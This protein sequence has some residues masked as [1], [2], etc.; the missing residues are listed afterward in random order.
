MVSN[1]DFKHTLKRILLSSL[2]ESVTNI[3]SESHASSLLSKLNSLKS[4]IAKVAQVDYD[5]W[6]E[7]DRDTYGGGGICHIIADS[8]AGVL[9]KHGISAHSHSLD[10]KQHVVTI[11][12]DEGEKTAYMVDIPEGIYENG[13]GFSWTKIPGVEFDEHSVYIDRIDYDDWIANDPDLYL[14]NESCAKMSLRET[15]VRMFCEDITPT[16]PSGKVSMKRITKNKGT[17]KAHEIIQYEFNTKSGNNVKVQLSPK[18]DNSYD[19][20]FYVNDTLDDASSTKGGNQRDIEILNGVLYVVKE[21]SKRLKAKEL[22][23]SAYSGKGDVKNYKNL[24]VSKPKQKLIQSF[25][26]VKSKLEQYEPVEIP[27]SELRLKL[28]KDTGKPLNTLYDLDKEKYLNVI[29][30]LEN[31]IDDKDYFIEMSHKLTDMISFDRSSRKVFTTKIDP[32]DE[33]SSN[34]TK[35]SRSLISNSEGGININKNR[36]SSL[37]DRLMNKYFS[38]EWDVSKIRDDF[39]LKKK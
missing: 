1:D 21:V 32:N 6:D 25:Q 30:D 12:Y 16:K 5:N 3:F 34:I 9:S 18:Y 37:Y 27:P 15:I 38:D 17:M 39:V 22:T 8:V 28:S 4:E 20:V 7:E 19:V 29:N 24:D 31:H 13:G 10:Y 35:Y 14:D 36:R 23:F 26:N 11:A 2:K 33:L